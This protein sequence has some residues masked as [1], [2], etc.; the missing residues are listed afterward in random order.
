MLSQTTENVHLLYRPINC[1]LVPPV[2]IVNVV[3]II[4]Y[5]QELDLQALADTFSKRDEIVDVTYEPADNH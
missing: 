1:Y 4:T 5:R 2:E 3:G